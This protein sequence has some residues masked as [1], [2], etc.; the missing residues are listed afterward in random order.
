MGQIEITFCLG[1]GKN[2]VYPIRTG[3]RIHRGGVVTCDWVEHISSGCTRA[4]SRALAA[5]SPYLVFQVVPIV[6]K[7]LEGGWHALI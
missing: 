1:D 3:N 6:L 7:T 5:M 4:P 2:R